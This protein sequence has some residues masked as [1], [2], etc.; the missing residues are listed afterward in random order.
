[1]IIFLI[2]EVTAVAILIKYLAGTP[3]WITS[4]II[5]TSSLAYT[6]YGGLRASIFTDNI[7]FLILI[8]LLIISFWLLISY[9]SLIFN[10]EYIKENQPNLLSYNNYTNFTAGFTFFLAVSATNLFHQG[11]WQR[12]YAAQN[13]K[14]LKKSLIISFILI[15]PIVFLMGF[16]GLVAISSNKSVVPDLS[17][18]YLLF[19]EKTLIVSLIVIFLAISLTISSIDTLINAISSI[20]IVDVKDAV[21]F[22][23]D[24][25]I[26]SKI[27][28]IFISLIAFA[29]S[30]KGISILYLFLLADLFCCSAVLSVF[31][32][33]YKKKVFQ[34]SMFSS[35]LLGLFWG[36][37]FFPYPDF[38][39]SLLVGVIIP[40]EYFPEYI[41][42]SL[43]FLSFLMATF[44]PI[45]SMNIVR[46]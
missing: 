18:F 28:L 8:T 46:K 30:S 40:K 16:T 22:K 29:I 25:L 17:F 44:L 24:S 11:N 34:K 13:N 38:S 5:I 23:G 12:I 42:N 14:V 27:I 10:F 36:L 26:F 32:G 15:I 45:I 1:M 19:S 37:L 31:L 2:A 6:L 33:F 3:L 9:N 4:I 20:I 21:R 35:I 41:S 43:L 7:Q 39:K